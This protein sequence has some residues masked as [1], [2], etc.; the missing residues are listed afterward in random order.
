MGR[1]VTM[2]NCNFASALVILLVS[3][4]TLSAGCTSEFRQK[5]LNVGDSRGADKVVL[6][7]AKE[8]AITYIAVDL[9][10]GQAR[11]V[12]PRRVVCAEPSPDVATAVSDAIQ[13]SVKASAS[14]KEAQGTAEGAY[15][16]QFTE[17]IAQL[18]SRLA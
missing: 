10:E 6:T 3:C 2:M 15:S 8:R 7:D 18:G 16:R 1:H 13:A 14:Y 12:R 9:S 4:L 11:R 17:S 5:S